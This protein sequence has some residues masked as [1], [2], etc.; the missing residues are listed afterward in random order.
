MLQTKGQA[1]YSTSFRLPSL[2][3]GAGWIWAQAGAEMG[4]GGQGG[5]GVG[6]G[7]EGVTS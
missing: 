7:L 1:I 3:Q 4:C 2:L 6:F 5:G